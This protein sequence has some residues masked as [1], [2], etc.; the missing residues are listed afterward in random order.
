MTRL[1]K[2]AGAIL[3]GVAAL[4]CASSSLAASGSRVDPNPANL[5]AGDYAVDPAHYSVTVKVPHG[6]STYTFRFN[7]IDAGFSYDPAKPEASQVKATGYLYSMS[8]GYDRADMVFPNMML[9][10]GKVARATFVSTAIVRSSPNKGKITGD[11]T[12]NGVTRPVVLD[13]VFNGSGPYFQDKLRLGFSATT[14]IKR[15]DYGLTQFLPDIGDDCVV[16][17]EIEFLPKK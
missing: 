15:S 14:T 11:F 17:I 7:V 10:A 16:N 1:W 5:P 2:R 13:T 4:A 12:L 3:A 6:F 9:G 8:T